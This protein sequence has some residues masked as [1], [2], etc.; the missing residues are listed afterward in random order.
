MG[1]HEDRE[2]FHDILA[3]QKPPVPFFWP[4][5]GYFGFSLESG[6]TVIGPKLSKILDRKNAPFMVIPAI[7]LDSLKWTFI[8]LEDSD[9]WVVQH[10]RS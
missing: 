9:V 5:A 4:M 10:S 6:R 2:T 7:V 1:P 8:W 3:N